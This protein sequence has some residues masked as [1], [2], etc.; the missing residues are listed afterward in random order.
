MVI[1][2]N[3]D[4]HPV[5]RAIGAGVPRI[6]QHHH[7]A[8][9][10]CQ[11]FHD[12]RRRIR[13]RIIDDHEADVGVALRQDGAGRHLQRGG[14]VEGGHCHHDARADRLPHRL[15]L[16]ALR[17]GAKGRKGISVRALHRTERR[18]RHAMALEEARHGPC[19]AR[20]VPPRQVYMRKREPEVRVRSLCRERR[21]AAQQRLLHLSRRD[22]LFKDRGNEDGRRLLV[23]R[24]RHA[25]PGAAERGVSCAQRIGKVE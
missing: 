13:A 9:L 10:G 8:V 15:R 24:F 2:W 21:K 23:Q 4:E 17:H 22:T 16:R 1:A 3:L 14:G 25:Q 5:L 19:P 11:P 20:P 6:A 12:G 7:P 18:L